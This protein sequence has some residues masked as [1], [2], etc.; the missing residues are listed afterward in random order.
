M[1]EEG[2]DLWRILAE[3]GIGTNIYKFIHQKEVFCVMEVCISECVQVAES[4]FCVKM[5]QGWEDV[6]ENKT[7]GI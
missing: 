4:E 3:V 2:R 1:R 6:R 5:V 7:D